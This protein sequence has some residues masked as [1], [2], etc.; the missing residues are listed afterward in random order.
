MKFNLPQVICACSIISAI[1]V[2]ASILDMDN[3]TYD[4]DTGLYWLDVTETY[5]MS[6][7]EVILET[8]TGGSLP[9][10]RYATPSELDQ[11]IINFGYSPVTQNCGYGVLVCDEII[12]GD[13]VI[14]ETIINTL[15]DTQDIF[16]DG[17]SQERDVSST[18][19]GYTRGYLQQ[20]L[21]QGVGQYTIPVGFI[22]DGE[23]VYRDSGLYYGDTFDNVESFSGLLF[24]D[25]TTNNGLGSFLVATSLVPVPAAAWLFGSGLLGLLGFSRKQST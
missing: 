4:T 3:M 22:S 2:N 14:I 7:N 17:S 23:Y 21:V 18:G 5:G 24:P 1:N 6:Y 11:L 13:N 15:G 9:G 12:Q 10:W 16:L 19:A 25:S 8:S 20:D